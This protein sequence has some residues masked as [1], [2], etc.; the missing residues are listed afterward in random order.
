ML[1]RIVLGLYCGGVIAIPGTL[2]AVQLAAGL[3]IPSL[4]AVFLPPDRVRDVCIALFVSG[5]VA[6]AFIRKPHF[7]WPLFLAVL[8]AVLAAAFVLTLFINGLSAG[9]TEAGIAVACALFSLISGYYA[10]RLW[11]RTGSG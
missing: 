9:P 6:G 5:G 4:N 8:A 11:R 2:L 7:L 1:E 10:W 3:D